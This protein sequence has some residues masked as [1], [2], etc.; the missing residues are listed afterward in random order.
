MPRTALDGADCV[1]GAADAEDA[2]IPGEA[3]DSGEVGEAEPVVAVDFVKGSGPVA[4]AGC[5]N[6]SPFACEP[7]VL[8]STTATT[9]AA[10][11]TAAST[12]TRGIDDHQWRRGFSA[13][14]PPPLDGRPGGPG[15]GWDGGPDRGPEGGPVGRPEAGGS[16][17]TSTPRVGILRPTTRL[18]PLFPVIT[19]VCSSPVPLASGR[20]RTSWRALECHAA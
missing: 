3:G 5:R 4:A 13:P 19:I 9:T 18:A 6:T 11:T 20:G 16:T 15:G 17:L 2:G 7:P 12:A 8:V 1:P 10:T 14:P